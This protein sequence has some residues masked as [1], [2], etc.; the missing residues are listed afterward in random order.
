LPETVKLED[1]NVVDAPNLVSPSEVKIIDKPEG[2]QRP[3]GDVK[4]INHLLVPD[5]DPRVREYGGIKAEPKKPWYEHVLDFGKVLVPYSNLMTEQGRM[6]HDSLPEPAK[7][8][9]NFLEFTKAL[10]WAIGWESG[11]AFMGKRGLKRGSKNAFKRVV[12]ETPVTEKEIPIVDSVVKDIER[13]RTPANISKESTPLNAVA[14]KKTFKETIGKW[15]HKPVTEKDMSA[16]EQATSL[17]HWAV[18][19]YPKLK[20]LYGI[21]RKRGD[22]RAELSHSLLEGSEDFFKLKGKDLDSA[23]RL[24][25]YGDSKGKAFTTKELVKAGFNKNVIKGYTSVRNTLDAVKERSFNAL[26]DGGMPDD[27]IMKLRSDIGSLEGYFPR[28]RYGKYYIRAEKKGAPDLYKTEE[29]VRAHYNSGFEGAKIRRD[30]LKSGYKILDEGKINKLPEEV[31]FQVSPEAIS[32]V[33]EHASKGLDDVTR[34]T[35]REGIANSFKERGWMGHGISR[36]KFWEGFE[37]GN[38]KRVLHDYL[39]GY[40]GFE[41]KMDAARKFQKE[42][43]GLA[44]PKEGK[45]LPPKQ[46]EW[47]TKYV[48]DTMANS[49]IY[50]KVSGQLRAAAFHKYL[51][52]IIKSGVVNLTQNYIAAAP[53]LSLETP[54]AYAKLTKAMGDIV[55]N[56]G[57]KK[58][59]GHEARALRIAL[60]KGWGQDQYMREMLGRVSKYGGVGN[61]I[62]KVAGAPM[63]IAERFNRQ[64]TFLAAYR[65]ILKKG[66]KSG[67]RGEEAFEHAVKKAG[68]VV[69]DSHFVYGKSNLPGALRGTSAAKIARSAY[70]FRTFTHNYLN[71]V[72]N[73]SRQ[74][75]RGKIAAAKSLAAIGTIGG[76]SS[77]PFFKTVEGVA[78]K[79]GYN[80]RGY[81]K[82]K[83]KEYFGDMAGDVALYGLPA[84]LDLDIGGSIGIEIPG[85]RA[86][87]SDNFAEAAGEAVV[88]VLGVPASM[89]EDIYSSGKQLYYGDMYRAVEE[90]PV[91]PALVSNA[92]KAR[93][94]HKEGA[95]SPS[96][97]IIQ[98]GGEYG[99][100][101]LSTAQAIKRGV[102]GFQSVQKSEDYRKFKARRAE[103]NRWQTKGSSIKSNFIKMGL[104]YGFDSKQVERS[105]KLVEDFNAKKPV[106]IGELDPGNWIDDVY[107]RTKGWKDFILEEQVK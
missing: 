21:E 9:K 62:K 17:P 22:A 28:T 100:S 87:N 93:R 25:I 89:F 40:A 76:V 85:Q 48:R 15:Y 80:P 83:T 57:G 64:S 86:L 98:R 30:L 79:Y 94:E 99:P 33:F 78:Q 20:S 56:Y 3:I 104:R 42:L 66:I 95:T 10:D 24:L 90:S 16:L 36:Q 8:D 61:T 68:R 71:L 43:S 18:K 92:M 51:G 50:D 49:D 46:Y 47:A 41:T 13:V 45:A 55:A 34:N 77:I 107:G 6:L 103:V 29:R 60:Q 84:V 75:T 88:D 2:N 7:A 19:K 38:L 4:A 27:E 67:L 35:L 63:G 52:G 96:G 97:A 44:F 74:G 82:E 12:D 65:A 32:A 31:Y 26:K 53:R 70:T 72:S 14:D 37:T 1:V 54:F 73:L 23:Q 69:E 102:F 11:L 106:Y 81:I 91:T 58:L 105:W 5:V 59:P 39:N 101:K